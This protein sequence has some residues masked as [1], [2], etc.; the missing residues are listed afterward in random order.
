MAAKNRE[1]IKK[2]MKQKVAHLNLLLLKSL[3]EKEH[4]GEETRLELEAMVQGY[5]LRWSETA[6]GTTRQHQ[7]SYRNLTGH[8]VTCLCRAV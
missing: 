7:S 6:P 8:H 5:H 3:K 2:E 4:C 1:T